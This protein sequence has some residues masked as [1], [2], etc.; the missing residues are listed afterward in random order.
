M[1]SAQTRSKTLKK[2]LVARVGKNSPRAIRISRR[3]SQNSALESGWLGLF[4]RV[5][6]LTNRAET[7]KGVEVPLT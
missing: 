5:L 3:A 6:A 4:T 2:G 1:E 7:E